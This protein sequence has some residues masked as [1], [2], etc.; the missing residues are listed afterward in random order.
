MKIDFERIL[1]PT[2][3][4]HESDE[5]MRYAIDLALAYEAKLFVCHCVGSS[6]SA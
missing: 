1:C 5:A 2:D 3:L 6:L 4:S